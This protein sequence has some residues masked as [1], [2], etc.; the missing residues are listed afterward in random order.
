MSFLDD[1]GNVLQ[2]VVVAPFLPAIAPLGFINRGKTLS[3]V[4][5]GLLSPDQAKDAA[6]ADVGAFAI[7]AGV[8]GPGAFA[9]PA[10][11]LD[12]AT[13][14]EFAANDAAFINGTPAMS[15]LVEGGV[16]NPA[17]AFASAPASAAPSGGGLFSTLGSIG[18]G[19]TKFIA[20][21]ATL[22]STIRT[23]ATQWLGGGS[24]VATRSAGPVN[25]S[26][27]SSLA[28]DQR[29]AS[30]GSGGVA[31]LFGGASGSPHSVNAGTSPIL[32]LGAGALA[33]FL[34]YKWWNEE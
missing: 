25:A 8:A 26:G 20:G 2:K 24:K 21:A 9:A 17:T 23:V 13:A 7:A 10:A 3:N 6:I 32:I 29:L 16:S 27:A 15:N 34:L 5:G 14:S 12:P 33:L 28:N 22:S 31:G 30:A 11:P 19:F 1:V 4:S 18:T